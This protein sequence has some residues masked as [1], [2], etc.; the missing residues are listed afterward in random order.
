MNLTLHVHYA[1]S[2]SYFHCPGSVVEQI[3]RPVE[4]SVALQ[5]ALLMHNLIV[6][7]PGCSAKALIFAEGLFQYLF[8][9]R[10][11]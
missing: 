6:K 4:A 7:D 8:E 10:R 3:L 2:H 1:R 11:S 5:S 9:L